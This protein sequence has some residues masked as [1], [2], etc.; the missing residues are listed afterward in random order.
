MICS[1]RK[2]F[3]YYHLRSRFALTPNPPRHDILAATACSRRAG[4][5][6]GHFI[7]SS[8]G[9]SASF[10]APSYLTTRAAENLDPN[11]PA[12]NHPRMTGVACLV[13]GVLVGSYAHLTR[14]YN[15]S[16]RTLLMRPGFVEATTAQPSAGGGSPRLPAQLKEVLG[17]QD[18]LMTGEPRGCGTIVNICCFPFSPFHFACHRFV[19]ISAD[20]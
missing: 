1:G 14:I 11:N 8:I 15:Q 20:L 17:Y 19:Y 4:C 6:L 10:M 12:V 16:D 13:E 2:S 7:L 5:A 9:A 18:D 3:F